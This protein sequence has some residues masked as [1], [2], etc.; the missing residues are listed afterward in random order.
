MTK[1]G[2]YFFMGILIVFILICLIMVYSKTTGSLE[3]GITVFLSIIIL[4]VGIGTYFL[5]SKV[6]M[7]SLSGLVFLALCI[8]LV[9]YIVYTNEWVSIPTE[10][11]QTIESF[12]TLPVGYQNQDG[13]FVPSYNSCLSSLLDNEDEEDSSRE[14]QLETEIE[15]AQLSCSRLGS[16]EEELQKYQDD[17]SSTGFSQGPCVD[18]DGNVGIKLLSKGNICLPL[19]AIYSEDCA[20]SGDS[21]SSSSSTSGLS[22]EDVS[23][24]QAILSE[25]ESESECQN[26]DTST[27]IELDSDELMTACYNYYIPLDS[28]CGSLARK[29]NKTNFQKYGVKKYVTCPDERNKRRAI[30][31]PF[32]RKGLPTHQRNTTQCL[33]SGTS[34][35]NYK[36]ASLCTTLGNQQNQNLVPYNIKPYDCP[37]GQLRAECIPKNVY[38]K[39]KEQGDFYKEIFA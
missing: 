4:A 5:G 10:T 30:C 38:E 11:I 16:L 22:S 27:E 18:S 14:D 33:N 3:I 21:G 26:C 7:L 19:D 12:S 23:R 29:N 20:C 36:F 13:K 1:V 2:D 9:G 32:Y 15:Q 24:C 6:N 8:L 25:A 35:L 31:K 39:I 28:L 17:N 37:F 34:N